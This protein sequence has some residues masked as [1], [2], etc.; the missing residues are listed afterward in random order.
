MANLLRATYG[1]APLDV[2][3]KQGADRIVLA[4]LAAVVG[5]NRAARVWSLSRKPS[6]RA[7]AILPTPTPTLPVESEAKFTALHYIGFVLLGLATVYGLVTFWKAVLAL[8]MLAV[9]VAAIWLMCIRSTRMI[10]AGAMVAALVVMSIAGQFMPKPEAGDFFEEFNAEHPDLAAES[11]CSLALDNGT[12]GHAADFGEA[13]INSQMTG[14]RF[15][16]ESTLRADG[17]YAVQ[18]TNKS[19]ITDSTCP[20]RLI[21]ACV[22]SG[23][24]VQVT[25]PLRR[26][27]YIA[28]G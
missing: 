8:V 3:A 6:S 18:V 1:A 12:T 9:A 28:C 19:D 5:D 17:S 11:A 14:S 13:V 4:D 21:G 15:S 20:A 16:A 24:D 23:D 27:G 25:S 2:L 7:A 10:G 26:A 22:V